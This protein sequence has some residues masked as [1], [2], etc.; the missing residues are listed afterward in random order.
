MNNYSILAVFG[1][2][3]I[4]PTTNKRI[5]KKAYAKLVKQYHPEEFP[6]EWQQIHQAYEAAMDYAKHGH[7]PNMEDQLLTTMP[8]MD[9]SGTQKLPQPDAALQEPPVDFDSLLINCAEQE[10]TYIKEV[11][12]ELEHIKWK[13]DWNALMTL[14]SKPAFLYAS[15][16][17]ENLREC[18]EMLAMTPIAPD[19]FSSVIASINQLRE[20]VT[21]P[22]QGTS[23]LEPEQ[24]IALLDE[25]AATAKKAQQRYK[26]NQSDK[27][28]QKSR[29]FWKWA[30]V[31]A[32]ILLTAYFSWMRIESRTPKAPD[33]IL[34]EESEN[35]IAESCESYLN[36]K[37]GASA[38]QIDSSQVDSAQ[39]TSYCISLPAG[40]V[41]QIKAVQGENVHFD[42][43][44]V[45][46]IMQALEDQIKNKLGQSELSLVPGTSLVPEAGWGIEDVFFHEKYEGDLKDF[47]DREAA[48][49]ETIFSNSSDYGNENGVFVVYIKDMV[50]IADRPANPS[51]GT[52]S[53][54]D[55]QLSALEQEYHVQLIALYTPQEYYDELYAGEAEEGASVKLPATEG[56]IL[57]FSPIFN[58]YYSAGYSQEILWEP[59][60]DGIWYVKEDP[61]DIAPVIQSEIKLEN[62]YQISIAFES[63]EPLLNIYQTVIIDKEMLGSGEKAVTVMKGENQVLRSDEYAEVGRYLLLPCSAT[64]SFTIS[65]K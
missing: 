22:K 31:M 50:S 59:A 20:A 12:S 48:Y 62:Q 36:D 64:E 26:D 9:K 8:S 21:D 10:Q 46:E 43:I 39:N 3:H 33:V 28:E 1:A 51:A 6:E 15:Q 61:E 60:S 57:N 40:M 19:V 52:L 30:G 13:R 45:Q 14:L 49:R 29:R 23:A 2:L 18:C 24:M 55:E 54:Y 34:Y 25:L 32:S 5:I 35:Q 63:E 65:W 11:M 17:K 37:Y 47:A 7:K 58:G 27:Q 44:Q 56:S 38:Y 53:Q 4:E 42:D 41:W 16:A